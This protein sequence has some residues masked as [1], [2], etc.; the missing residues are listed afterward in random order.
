MTARTTEEQTPAPRHRR[1]RRW[2]TAIAMGLLFGGAAALAVYYL[3]P[4][5]FVA[6]S[7]VYIEASRE[8]LLDADVLPAED[9]ETYKKTEMYRAVQ[10]PTL[11]MALREPVRDKQLKGYGYDAVGDLPLMKAQ[12][13]PVDWL[14]EKMDAVSLSEEFFEIEIAHSDSP[15]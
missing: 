7:V 4:P 11:E 8:P 6:T 13:Y 10:R 3:A 5:D 1:L 2:P 14:G 15:M 9:F 12:A